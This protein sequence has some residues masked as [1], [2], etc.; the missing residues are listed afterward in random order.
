MNDDPGALPAEIRPA[1][2]RPT[3]TSL[4]DQP[5]PAF[6]PAPDRPAGPVPWPDY[7]LP[8]FGAWDGRFCSNT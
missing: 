1:E 8:E 6:T 7:R 2:I 3:E 4:A 5:G